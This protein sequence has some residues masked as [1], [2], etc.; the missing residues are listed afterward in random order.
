MPFSRLEDRRLITGSGRYTSDWSFPGQVYAHF[1]RADRAHARIRGIDLTA[2][3]AM[4]GV[5]AVITVE[6]AKRSGFGSLPSMAPLPGRGGS[7]MTKVHR[8]VLA[9]GAVRFV[10]ECVACVVAETAAL[11]ADAAEA[12]QVDYEDLPAVMSAESAMAPG[13]PQLHDGL[14][15]NVPYDFETGDPTA[16]DAGFARAARVVKLSLHNQRVV[17]NPMEP[18]ACLVRYDAAS[19]DYFVHACTQGTAGM[20]GQIVTT[21][22]IADDKVHIVAEDVGGGFGVRYNAYPEYCALM[23]AARD[24]GRPVK[25]TATRSEVFL[26]DEQARG[27]SSTGELALDANNNFLALRLEFL[28]DMGAYLAPTGPIVAVLSIR[29]CVAGVYRVPAAYARIRIAMT[30]TVPMA[31]YRGAGRPVITYMLERLVEQA[32]V[33]LGVDAAALRRQN[34][35]PPAAMP[36]KTPSG[37][38]YDCGDFPAVLTDAVRLADWS[39]FAARQTA[40]ASSGRLRGIGMASYIEATAAGASKDEVEARFGGHG[41]ITLYT[42]SHSHGQGHETTYAEVLARVLGLP[43]ERFRLRNG[44]PTVRLIGNATGGSRTLIGVGSALTVAASEIIAKGKELAARA[45]EAAS[46][47]IVFEKGVYRIAGTDRSVTLDS[48]I[49][50]HASSGPHPLDTR[51]DGRFGAT[52]PNGCHIAEVEIDPATGVVSIVR[53][54]GVDD[55]GTIINHAIVE[56]Q[57]QGG[58]TQ[59]AGQVLGEHGIYDPDTGQLLSGSFVDYPMPRAL[60][61]PELTLADHPVPTATNPLGA[62]GVGEAGVSGSLPALMNAIL[63]ALRPAGVTHFEMP[64]TPARVW[65]AIRAARAGQPRRFAYSPPATDTADD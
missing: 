28:N 18:K 4:P 60:L 7:A 13:A 52:F 1:L 9:D 29:A 45:L 32:A 65:G 59:G 27:V 55:A 42:V 37:I 12:I 2:A 25:W 64:A 58:I 11:A 40:A 51:A 14:P 5:L 30:N 24:V 48:L 56:G 3:R 62:K 41:E 53:Y 10:G 15:G 34:M 50:R 22:G 35:I 23:L 61:V 33:E 16:V 26:S 63:S 8:P 39:G 6:D 17:G 57:M 31:A 49:T 46:A 47:D 44:D 38:E 36:F 21:T 54:T 43:R 20:R 19:G